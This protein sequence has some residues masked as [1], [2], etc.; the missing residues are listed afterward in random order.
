MFEQKRF[1]G[2]CADPTWTEELREGHQNVDGEDEEF[3]A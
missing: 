1:C 2:E 3:A